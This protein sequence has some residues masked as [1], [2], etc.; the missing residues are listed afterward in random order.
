[1]WHV[2]ILECTNGSLYTG[3]TTDVGRR[4][5]EHLNKSARYT[6]YNPPVRLVYSSPCRGKAAAFRR[7]AEIK[8]WTRK[9]KLAFIA[10][11]GVMERA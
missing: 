11:E 7:E 8:R 4:F 6:S 2:Y 9:R 1:M 3:V 10:G 5:S